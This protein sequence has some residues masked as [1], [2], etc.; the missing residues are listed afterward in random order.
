MAG[1]P[2]RA[3]GHQDA[4]R[5]RSGAGLE[6][7]AAAAGTLSEN[8]GRRSHQLVS[9]LHTGGGVGVGGQQVNWRKGKRDRKQC[10]EEHKRK[11]AAEEE[12]LTRKERCNREERR[13]QR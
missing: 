6:A 3:G 11:E 9:D 1:S 10:T 8:E 5:V 13:H 4:L 2:C 12:I 7:A